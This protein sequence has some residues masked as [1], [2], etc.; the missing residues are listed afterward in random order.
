[1]AITTPPDQPT[2]DY[3]NAD[4]PAPL[5][6]WISEYADYL[7]S[8][9]GFDV[10]S[11]RRAGL[12][13]ATISS[14]ISSKVPA[15]R[16]QGQNTS[17]VSPGDAVAQPDDTSLSDAFRYGLA[18]AAHGFG[19]TLK[20]AGATNVGQAIEDAIAMPTNYQPMTV[21]SIGDAYH[22]GGISEAAHAAARWAVQEA[23]NAAGYAGA[24]LA[25]SALAG[26]IGGAAG[27][28]SYAG[29]RTF[30]ENLDST[31]ATSGHQSPTASDY[32]NAALTSGLEGGAA[33][34]GGRLLP[35]AAG[36]VGRALGGTARALKGLGDA[37]EEVPAQSKLALLDLSQRIQQQQRKSADDEADEPDSDPLR[38]LRALAAVGIR[39][40][41]AAML[42]G[43][44]RGE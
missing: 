31:V 43:L 6:P 40:K 33:V 30:G 13:D 19:E 8:Q 18:R 4:P 20:A 27:V 26:P 9:Y 5:R 41:N 25:G 15:I 16:D 34:L 42:L 28:M 21:S 10:H 29:G 11:M 24:G 17:G 35:E 1:M 38:P 22:R 12:D 14:Y 44:G 3:P 32:T 39:L 2:P 23:P 7:G 37:V 36:T